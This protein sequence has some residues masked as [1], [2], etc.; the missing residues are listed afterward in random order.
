M[1][2]IMPVC[3]LYEKKPFLDSRFLLRT[4]MMQLSTIFT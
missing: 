2:S 4:F 1:C 3:I